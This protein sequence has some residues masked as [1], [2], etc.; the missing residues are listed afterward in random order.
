MTHNQIQYHTL[1]ETM[2]H[3]R[4]TEGQAVDELKEKK[5]ASLV[6]EDQNA[7]KI[8]ETHRTNVANE[9]IASDKNAETARHNKATELETHANNVA[10]A[11]SHGKN[12]WQAAIGAA[13]GEF[14]R[15]KL[16]DGKYNSQ[17]LP[18]SAVYVLDYID[19]KD[20]AKTKDFKSVMDLLHRTEERSV[21]R[22]KRKLGFETGGGGSGG[23]F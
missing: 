9:L 12:P 1:M 4:A 20:A 8:E 17:L 2:Q 5:R 11:I 18:D 14:T 10:T 15:E 21:N 3:N 13:A 23:S 22:I 19:D 6:S 7:Q 16:S